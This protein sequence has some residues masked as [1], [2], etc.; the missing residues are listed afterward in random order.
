MKTRTL[1]LCLVSALAFLAQ[2]CT[3]PLR[4]FHQI[5]THDPTEAALPPAQTARALGDPQQ[6]QAGVWSLLANLGIGVYT[7]SGEQVMPGSERGEASFWLY[8]F[9]VPALAGMAQGIPV[10]F[11]DYA[12]QLA[13][14]GA[15]GGSQEL[16]SLYREVYARHPDH[17]LV[18]LLTAM[19][20]DFT[21]GTMLTPL[22][23]WLL[24]LDT[25][26]PPN[27]A[28]ASREPGGRLAS[29]VQ[30]GRARQTV[31]GAIQGGNLIPYWGLVRSES[32]LAALFQ[33]REVYYAIHGPLIA[34][35]ASYHLTASGASAH[36]GH[37]GKGDTL[38]YTVRVDVNYQP[39]QSIPVAGISCGALANMD[40]R[41]LLGG[42]SNVLVDWVIPDVFYAHGM[43]EDEEPS[44]DAAGE[45]RLSFRAQEEEA[46][47][48]GLFLEQSGEVSAWLNL[49]TGFISAG[50]S[51][52][53]LLQFVPERVPVEGQPA[54]VSWHEFCDRFTLIFDEELH[55][56]APQVTNNIF[57]KG[58]VE[59]TIDLSK[60]PPTLEGEGTLP[61]T[62]TGT[63]GDCPAQNS[64]FDKVVLRGTVTIGEGDAPPTLHLSITH[65]MQLQV[66]A[67]GGGGGMPTP[68]TLE[69]GEI[70]MPLKDGETMSW[71]LSAP[72]VNARTTYTLEV[73]C[74]Q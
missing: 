56:Q 73:P 5:D 59:V 55:Q 71:P 23:A 39:W 62:G 68:L 41:V 33:A 35:A 47:G 34:Q 28:Q 6:A 38:E 57:I 66:Q 27:D 70:E 54:V 26:V 61:V 13:A 60:D 64:G 17:P 11:D 58:P 50:I 15:E 30:P 32:D 10:P 46:H 20:V 69:P 12:A 19:G 52:P 44:T 65:T 48:I 8:D 63:F 31:C 18:Q 2:G 51:D 67:C 7:S 36:E 24:L 21:P 53:R 74:G 43:V 16:L 4:S 45:A 72:T 49:R 22:E 25:F 40:F 42:L 37:E 1:S 9:E 14:L 29:M 3:L